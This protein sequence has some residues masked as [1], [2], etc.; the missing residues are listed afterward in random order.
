MYDYARRY[1]EYYE[2]MKKANPNTYTIIAQCRSVFAI[3]HV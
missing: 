2:A 1:I 3:G